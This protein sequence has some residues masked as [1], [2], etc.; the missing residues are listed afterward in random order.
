MPINYNNLYRYL[1]LIYAPYNLLWRLLSWVSCALSEPAKSTKTNLPINYLSF[2]IVIWQIACD[3]EEV[4]FAT[5]ACVVLDWFAIP[6]ILSNYFGSFADLYVKFYTWILLFPSY[7]ILNCC[8]LFRRSKH[9]PPY[10][11]KKLIFMA[12]LFPTDLYS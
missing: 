3:L 5:V 12:N 8:F 10:N 2:L 11:S 4:S 7:K 1:L 9:R 6:M